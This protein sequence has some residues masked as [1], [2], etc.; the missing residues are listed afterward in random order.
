MIKSK[1][2]AMFTILSLILFWELYV[3]LSQTPAYVLPAPSLIIKA[4]STNFATIF[5]HSCT[6]FYES[7]IGIGI[8]LILALIIG[9]LMD[10]S[11]LLHKCIYPILLISQTIPAIVLSPLLV[12]YFGFGLLPKIIIVVLMCFFPICIN[13]SESLTKSNENYSNLIK[14]YGGNTYHLYKIVKIPASLKSI[15]A[16]LKIASAYSIGGAVVGEWIGAT[17]GLGYYIIRLNNSYALDVVFACVVAIILLSFLMH[18]IVI[19][20]EKI[21]IKH[22]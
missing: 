22:Y 3:K 21:F 20:L 2:P 13:F 4:F 12:I 18:A 16:G 14:S 11:P 6:T 15:F 19:I 10:I 9:I 5:T 17:K 8:S 1:F 7:L